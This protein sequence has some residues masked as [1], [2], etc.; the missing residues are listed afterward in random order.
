MKQENYEFFEDRNICEVC[1]DKILI[2]AALCLMPFKELLLLTFIISYI[3]CQ[4]EKFIDYFINKIVKL[5]ISK[6]IITYFVL[7]SILTLVIAAG[8]I[9]IFQ[10]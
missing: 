2:I 1:R 10:N 7:A 4:I 3:L 9:Y 8:S 5:N 6:K